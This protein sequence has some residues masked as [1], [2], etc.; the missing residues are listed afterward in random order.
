MVAA[1]AAIMRSAAKSVQTARVSVQAGSN[2][3]LTK[4][5][6]DRPGVA[7]QSTQPPIGCLQV[8][9]SVRQRLR[10]ASALS[11][12]AQPALFT[13]LPVVM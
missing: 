5:K 9:P 8:K 10:A 12:E 6:L 4:S 1:C 13:A 7:R 11:P 3:L 2:R